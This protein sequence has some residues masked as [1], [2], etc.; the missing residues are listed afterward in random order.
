MHRAANS[1]QGVVH[2]ATVEDYL[3]AVYEICQRSKTGGVASNGDVAEELHLVPGTVT[4]MVQRLAKTGL[5]VYEPHRGCRLTPAGL[6]I[7]ERVIRRHCALEQFLTEVLALDAEQVHDE[8]ENLEH[9]VSDQLITEIQRY[10]S[11]PA[12][13]A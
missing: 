10:L 9:A 11:N 2:S 13:A 5:L 7:A 8:A 4:A 6:E 12:R 1:R 3:K